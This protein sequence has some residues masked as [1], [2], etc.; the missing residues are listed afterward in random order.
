MDP[1]E[2]IVAGTPQPGGSKNAFARRNPKWKPGMP[3]YLRYLHDGE[4]RPI[5]TVV[6]DNPKTAGWKK[7]VKAAALA[8]TEGMEL[9]LEGALIVNMTFYVGRPKGHFGTGRNARLLKDSAPLRPPVRPDALKLARPVEDAL[10]GVLW[11]DDAQTTD[12]VIRKRYAPGYVLQG[13]GGE[14]VAI[15]VMPHEHNTV[16]EQRMSAQ[17][18]MT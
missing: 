2:I 12:L 13:E 11:G 10:T 8:Q 6:D 4:G 9:P 5:L 1:I 17:T 18:S 16:G 7:A 14:Y 15:R 3:K